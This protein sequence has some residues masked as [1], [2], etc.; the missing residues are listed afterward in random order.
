MA[1]FLDK[2]L[3]LYTKIIL[4]SIQ[5]GVFTVDRDWKILSF[6]RSA[7]KITGVPKEEAIGKK[8]CEVFRANICE[9][10]CALRDTLKTG[11]PV[12]DQKI[13]IINSDGTKIPVNIS[14]ALLKDKGKVIGG[15]ETFRDLRVMEELRKELR[16]KYTFADIISKNHKIHEY[17][18]ILPEIAKSNAT[19]L[20]QGESGTG[21]E[22]FA[23]AIHNLSLRRKKKFVAINCGALP[24]N[25]LE[26]E[27]FGYKKG[28]FTD[29][30]KDKP[31]RFEIAK[32]GTLFLDEIGDISPALQIRLLRVLQEK[33]YEPLGS[34][35]PQKSDVRIIAATN[36]NLDEL[37]K[38]NSFRNDLYYRINVIKL[39]LPA[40]RSR[41]EDITL[42][43]D[44]FFNHFNNIM[45]KQIDSLSPEV[46]N[47]LMNHDFPGNIRELENIIEHAF[48]LCPNTQI[49]VSHLPETLRGKQLTNDKKQDKSSFKDLEK[50]FIENAL[51]KNNWNRLATA[52]YLKIHKSTLFRKIKAL[53]IKLPDTD[54]RYKK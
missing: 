13:Y 42:L 6:N 14:T 2:K 20:I 31:G 41:K 12:I 29:A 1:E 50:T 43:V 30:K 32:G 33:I 27:L 7:E 35:E 36:K 39:D 3:N 38:N 24:D 28:A 52:R 4:D 51:R 16:S 18:K 10:G 8:C 23:K 44:H 25:L 45:N 17:F 5:D 49:E 40:L 47:I 53:D 34:I 22:L 54:G 46:L 48:V 26:S 9:S 21:K 15:V 19:V 11:N 37:V